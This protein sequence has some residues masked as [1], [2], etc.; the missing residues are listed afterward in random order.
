MTDLKDLKEAKGLK[1]CHINARSLINKIDQFRCHFENSDLDVVTVSETWLHSGICSSI[2]EM[3]GYQLFRWDRAFYDVH[4]STTKRGG[5]LVIYL[6]R[7]LNFTPEYVPSKCISD[8]DCEMQRLELCSGVQRN[9]VM[10]NLYRPPSGN[11][12]SFLDSLT[13]T[14]DSEDRVD[15]K[16]LVFLGDL[17][18]NYASKGHPDTKKLVSWQNKLGLTQHIK[19]STRQTKVS[20]SILDLVFTNMDSCTTAGTINLNI[21]DHQPVYFIKKKLKDV[22]TKICFRGR[23]YLGYNKEL[24]SDCLTNEIKAEFRNTEDP[25]E[26][27]DLMEKFLI[28]F[29]DSNCPIK[30][31]RSKENT[32][33]WFTHDI[34]TLSKDRD[35]AWAKAKLTNLDE[36]WVIARHLR[37]WTNNAVKQ[38][39]STFIQTELENNKK[40]PKKFWHN[41]RDVLPKSKSGTISIRNPLTNDPLPRDQQ[42]Q[43]INDFFANVGPNI[44]KKFGHEI[45]PLDMEEYIGDHLEVENISQPEVVRLIGTISVSK[46]SGLDNVS[47][48]VV[49]DFLMLIS[50]ELTILY[51]N[52]LS[53]GIFP[54]KWKVATVTPIPKIPNASNPTDLRPISL[55]P[56]PGKLLEKYI[57]TQLEHFLDDREFFSDFQSGFRK[58][59]STSSSFSTLLDD[60]ISNLNDSKTSVAAYLDVQKAFDSINHKILLTKLKACGIGDQFCKLLENY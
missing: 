39:K 13:K 52:I 6:K 58:G 29:L 9:I 1:F 21:S 33:A 60:V 31:F 41:I 2:I 20:R 25:N 48:R 11:V 5:G 49:K 27:W 16:E 28:N 42:A 35:R 38:A 8:G 55:L 32:P 44:T 45:A 23:S 40:D 10:Y 47:S 54:S 57:T 46:S 22:R 34:I 50:R 30:L 51:N 53:S 18:I 4:N 59:K 36:D 17:N 56:V 15:T 3:E 37:N 24:L 12:V 14:C 43:V 26:C 7:S 19:T